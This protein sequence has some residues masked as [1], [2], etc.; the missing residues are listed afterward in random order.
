MAYRNKI[1]VDR[2]G[3]LDV[4]A[5]AVTSDI[6]LCNFSESAYGQKVVQLCIGSTAV[7]VAVI[8]HLNTRTSAYGHKEPLDLP[9]FG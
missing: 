6:H 9:V 8:R 4:S 5:K 3:V 2:C 1:F 7:S